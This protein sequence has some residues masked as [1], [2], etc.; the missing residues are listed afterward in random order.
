MTG[1]DRP[2][3]AA[4]LR[5]RREALLPADVGLASGPRR[6]APGL[7]REEVAQVTGMSVDYYTR[8]EQSRGPQPSPAMLTALSRTLRLSEDERD[9]LFRVAGHAAPDRA[10]LRSHV[11]PALMRVFDRLQDTPALV[12]SA[13]GETL[14]AN[15]LAVILLGDPSGRRGLARYDVYRW[16][17]DPTARAIYP[18]ADH[19]RQSRAL[20]SALRAAHGLLG[21]RSL[22]GELATALV[23]TSDAFSLLW[24]QLGV[25]RRFEDHK[26]LLHAETGP[27]ELDCQVL[28]TEDQL[29]ALL[30]L[31]AAPGTAAAEQL[32]LLRVLGP[33][34]FQPAGSRDT[35]ARDAAE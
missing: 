32:A 27:I 1:V 22:A 20:V 10:A 25:G 29:Q 17:M 18:D 35:S 3:L 31:T 14:V 8:L 11:A 16:F 2:E 13:L 33:Q 28:F 21:A 4:F 23:Q 5:S 6:R 24:E 7:R 26:T 15:D 12:I 34:P 30:V 19:E 9:Y